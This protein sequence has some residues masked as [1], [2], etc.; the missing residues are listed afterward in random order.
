MGKK[1]NLYATGLPL[2]FIGML[3]MIISFN[4]KD[5]NKERI[6]DYSL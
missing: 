5:C 3:M 4:I 6:N 1:N 2:V